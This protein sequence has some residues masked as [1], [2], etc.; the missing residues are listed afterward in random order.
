MPTLRI[1]TIE[2]DVRLSATLVSGLTGAGFVVDACGD[3]DTGLD[4]LAKRRHDVVVLDRNLPAQ[5][6]I[7]VD[8]APRI[9]ELRQTAPST[10]VLLLTAM[11]TVEDRVGGLDAGADDYLVKPFAFVELIARI[12]TLARR[13]APAVLQIGS[14]TLDRA[15]HRATR[16]G[17]EIELTARQFSLLLFL[18]DHQG[19]VVSRSMIFHRVFDTQ[20]DPHTNVI[21]VHIRHLRQRLDVDGEPSLIETVRGVGY[22]LAS[23]R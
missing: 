23:P 21:D 19:D 8:T 3:F 10:R 12:K 5:N 1:L 17:V 9:K 6:G 16:A 13:S 14:L 2:D 18:A 7:P 4:L 22:R 20:F 15:A 11:D